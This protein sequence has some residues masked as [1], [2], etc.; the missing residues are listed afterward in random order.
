M[1]IISFNTLNA[2]QDELIHG[3][4]TRNDGVSTD[5][6]TSLNLATHVED[7]SLHVEQNRQIVKNNLQLPQAILFPDQCHTC[8]VKV[9]N[10]LSDDVSATDAL[11]TNQVN[12]PIA[13]MTADCVPILLYDPV[14]KV[15]AAIHAGWRGT[16]KGIVD[17]T[18][19]QMEIHFNCRPGHMVAAVGPCISKSEYEVDD[20]VIDQVKKMYQGTS[21][22]E[23][24]TPGHYLLDLKL[25]N[26]WQLKRMGIKQIEISEYCTFK[27][28]DLF[29]SARK[30]GIKSGRFASI[31]MLK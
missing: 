10:S 17:E 21:T 12:L 15:V 31:I 20:A 18:I 30:S 9:V 19:H 8:C 2:Y 25:L 16:V 3:V 4:T 23:T 27:D 29:F 13:V 22:Y 11:I 6:Y 14:K 1:R 7:N 28:H 24:T 26:K 5:M